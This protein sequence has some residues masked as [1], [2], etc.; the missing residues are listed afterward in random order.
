MAGAK[1]RRDLLPAALS[2]PGGSSPSKTAAQAGEKSLPRVSSAR[3]SAACRESFQDS[4]SR[5]EASE[6]DMHGCDKT[7]RGDSLA[8]SESPPS[9]LSGRAGV[10][11]V[12]SALPECLRWLLAR[13]A[14]G[15]T[16]ARR[17]RLA[18]RGRRCQQQQRPLGTHLGGPP[19]GGPPR[20]EFNVQRASPGLAPP[21]NRAPGGRRGSPLYRSRRI[22]RDIGGGE[23]ELNSSSSPGG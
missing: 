13:A 1:H 2:S 22:D 11:I 21:H 20:A 23:P 5:R 15:P 9:V 19:E 18:R 3:L 12:L 14:P 6:R 8:P 10:A 4:P 16:T 17:W 7:W